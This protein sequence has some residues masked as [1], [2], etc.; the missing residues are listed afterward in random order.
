MHP[1]RFS[2]VSDSCTLLKPDLEN[3]FAQVL[4]EGNFIKGTPVRDF[5]QELSKY[6]QGSE[7][8]PCG[9]GTDALQIALM[10]LDIPPGSE[11]IVPVF[12]Y[13][14]AAEAVALL[15]LV[16]VF[17]DVL[18]DT[19]TLDPASVAAKISYKTRAIIVVHLF[20]QCADLKTLTLLA[21]KHDLFI[22]ED[23]AQSLGAEYIAA[24]STRYFAGTVAHIGTTSF[25]PTKMLGA[26][27][28]GGALFTREE[29]LA[30]AIRQIA[31]HGQSRKYTYERVGINSRLDT[32]Q[33]AF[34]LVKLKY[35]DT[36]IEQRQL[37]AQEY[38]QHFQDS[39]LIQVP[40]RAAYSTHVF[41]HYVVQVPAEQRDN[42]RTYLLQKQIPTAVYYATPLHLQ[43][44]YYYLG[45][46][47]G[48]FPVAESLCQKVMALPLHPALTLE[49]VDYIIS[50]IKEYEHK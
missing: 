28:D 20:G 18:P 48:D 39:R 11:V 36:Y 22:V 3:A 43:P 33:A 19:F 41:N 29:E 35:L 24:D 26:L 15:G 50:C 31:S 49:Q 10:A 40:G 16:P 12:N 30:T 7:V 46:F 23:N 34:L 6:L 21:Q 37:L 8:I 1:I 44:A 14:S 42:L 13:V 47:Y 25:F 9:N 38:D 5:A 2:D 4:T 27:G 45:N 17:A 32:I